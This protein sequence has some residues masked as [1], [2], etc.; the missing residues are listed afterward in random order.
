MSLEGMAAIYTFFGTVPTYFA[1]LPHIS[2]HPDHLWGPV[3]SPRTH[4]I[5]AQCCG[6]CGTDYRQPHPP[7]QNEVTWDRGLFGKE[8]KLSGAPEF[9]AELERRTASS[10]PLWR[11]AVLTEDPSMAWAQLATDIREAA[12]RK[13]VNQRKLGPAGEYRAE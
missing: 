2:S 7:E 11:R 12:T 6:S 8:P 5:T 1:A 3:F 4:V 10:A 9:V 13:F